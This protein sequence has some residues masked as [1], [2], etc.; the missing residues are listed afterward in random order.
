MVSTQL[1][2]TSLGK[3]ATHNIRG[4]IIDGSTYLVKKIRREIGVVWPNNSINI[5]VKCYGFKVRNVF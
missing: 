2:L 1:A 4:L 5:P 3:A